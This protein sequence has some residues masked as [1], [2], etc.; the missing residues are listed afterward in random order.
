MQFC[1]CGAESSKNKSGLLFSATQRFKIEFKSIARDDTK[2][3]AV[4]N[5]RLFNV[6]TILTEWI[7]L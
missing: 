3:P 4:I 6:I 2:K 1:Q 5:G 7:H